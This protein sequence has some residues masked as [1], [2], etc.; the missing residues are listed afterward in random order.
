M[1]ATQVQCLALQSACAFRAGVQLGPPTRGRGGETS[2]T[3]K[4]E[5]AA[6][7]K[8]R[9]GKAPPSKWRQS[10]ASTKAVPP[11]CRDVGAQYGR[12]IV[13]PRNVPILWHTSPAACHPTSKYVCRTLEGC[14]KLQ[15]SEINRHSTHFVS[16]AEELKVTNNPG[17][18][19][20]GTGV[21]QQ[22]RQARPPRPQSDQECR[23]SPA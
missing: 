10:T 18:Q 6:P 8:R 3:K 1:A 11:K 16:N 13:D 9:G 7:P 14:P 12:L 5:K 21:S 19:Q 20:A 22:V 15:G 23:C 2:K 4:E 17:P